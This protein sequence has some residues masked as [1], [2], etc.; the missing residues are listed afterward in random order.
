MAKRGREG[1][2][3]AGGW[4]LA[5]LAVAELVSIPLSLAGDVMDRPGVRGGGH[6]LWAAFVIPAFALSGA[7]LVHLRPR[8]PVG[9]LLLASG[10]FQV[11]NLAADAYSTRALTDPDGTLPGGVFFAWL[12]SWTWPPSLLLPTLVLPALYPTGRP[13]NRYWLWHVRAALLGM[14]LLVLLMA[15]MPG[16]LGDTV[17]GTRLPW[18]APVWLGYLL[19]VPAGVLILGAALSVIIGTPL[20][21]VRATGPERQQLLWLLAVVLGMVG[22]LFSN[23]EPM[24]E[25]AYGL[26]PVAVAVGVLRYRLLGIEVVLRRTFLFLPLTLLVALV[27]G[28]LT[29]ILARLAPEGPLP[30]LLSSAVVAVLVIPVAGRLRVLVDRF[31]RGRPVD[32]LAVVDRVGSGMEV[33]HE[34]PVAAMLEAVASAAG[35]TFAAVDDPDARRLARVGE[36]TAVV[37]VV[38]LRHGGLTLGTL[39]VGPRRGQS[40]V[41]DADARL[42]AALAPQ[43]AVVVRS[44]TLTFELERERNRVTAA[45]LSERDRLRRDLHDGLGPSL[46]GIAL[47]LEAAARALDTDPVVRRATARAHP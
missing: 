23:L 21:I 45:T 14:A 43:L 34:D 20:R 28:G 2:V 46:S 22:A 18:E 3:R 4:L 41:T 6:G 13:P 9:W 12:A 47:G 42:L 31:V 37:E 35:S 27:I 33:R 1:W 24:L 36:P 32:S 40:R 39:T 11:T 16:G 44:Q 17:P 26:V 30:L 7:L 25:V 29:T 19:G 10:L 8:N 5:A 38:P 15:T